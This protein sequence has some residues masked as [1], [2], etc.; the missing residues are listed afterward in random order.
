MW[1]HCPAAHFLFS[2]KKYISKTILVQNDR[3]DELNLIAAD[4]IIG[5]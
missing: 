4:R 1:S 3:H 5:S 2:E